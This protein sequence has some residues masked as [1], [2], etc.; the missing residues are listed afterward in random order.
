MG[1]INLIKHGLFTIKS[2][3]ATCD[4][5]YMLV[6]PQSEKLRWSLGYHHITCL[7]LTSHYKLL[8][9]SD[10]GITFKCIGF[11]IA[12]AANGYMFHNKVIVSM[13]MSYIFV[14]HV[15]H[16]KHIYKNAIINVY[17]MVLHLWGYNAA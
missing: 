12:M 6:I 11:Q 5:Y 1:Y 16:S 3:K 10:S 17:R 8:E 9:H 15:W 7:M 4:T 14:P 13:G 2:M